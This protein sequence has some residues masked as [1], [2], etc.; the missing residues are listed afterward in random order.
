MYPLCFTCALTENSG[1]CHCSDRDRII[2]G[3][4]TSEEIKE[5]LRQGYEIVEVYQMVHYHERDQEMFP[6]YIK[7]LYVDKQEASGWPAECQ[8]DEQ[9]V[10]FC[11]EFQSR[12]GVPL[13]PA[14][15]QSNPGRRTIPKL[16]MNS[17]YGK[18]GQSANMPQTLVTNKRSE[19]WDLML[20]EDKEVLS[21]DSVEDHYIFTYKYV[22]DSMSNPGNTSVVVAVFITAYARLPFLREMKLLHES[23]QEVLYCDTDSIIYVEKSNSYRPDIGPFLGQLSDEIVGE[24]G[25]GATITEFYT[26]GPKSYC[27]RVKRADGSFDTKIKSK[28]LTLNLDSMESHNFEVIA[29]KAVK[30]SRGEDT[31]PTLVKQTQFTQ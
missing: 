29:E 26:T 16:G 12:M 14:K 6:N 11:M 9:K 4:W 1:L 22:D 13:D 19:A 24:Y 31:E 28:G 18:M 30:K 25:L 15:V 5:A 20:D 17:G 23:G 7:S 27:Y 21:E 2:R 3:K 8:T 10:S